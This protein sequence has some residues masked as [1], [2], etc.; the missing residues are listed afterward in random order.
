MGCLTSGFLMLIHLVALLVFFPALLITLPLHMIYD[1][2]QA[3]LR[4]AR[5]IEKERR[6]PRRRRR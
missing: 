3:A 2:Q 5:E 6:R 4:Q 1:N